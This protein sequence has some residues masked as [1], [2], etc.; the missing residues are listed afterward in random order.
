M[1]LIL[2]RASELAASAVDVDVQIVS[3][4]PRSGI[5]VWPAKPLNEMNPRLTRSG[6]DHVRIDLSDVET[7]LEGLPGVGVLT[8]ASQALF[9]AAEFLALNPHLEPM[10]VLASPAYGALSL[11]S[12]GGSFAPTLSEAVDIATDNALVDLAQE[13]GYTL[14]N[15]PAPSP[16]IPSRGFTLSP[17]TAPAATQGTPQ[18]GI[19]DIA[20]ARGIHVSEL[21]DKGMQPTEPSTGIGIGPGGNPGVT[22]VDSGTGDSPGGTPG[23]GQAP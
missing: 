5:E 1:C 16:T 19:V 11:I 6:V 4:R 15:A 21:N 12:R 2:V 18:Q 3:T 8:S 7:A 9:E 14:N 22:G 13:L 10:G 23:G 17:P 20:F